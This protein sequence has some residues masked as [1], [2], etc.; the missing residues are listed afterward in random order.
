MKWRNKVIQHY[1]FYILFCAS[2]ALTWYFHKDATRYSDRNE[3]WSDRAGYYIYLP[4]TIFYHFD[5]RKMPVDLDV[6]TGGG[7]SI[8]TLRNK[9][10]TKYTC[11]VALMAAPFFLASGVISR[12]AGYDSESGFSMLYMRMMSLAAVIYLFLGLWFLK[13]F[14]DHYFQAF[15]SFF[16]ITLIFIG[17]NLFYYSLIDGMMSHVYSFFLFALFL[18]AL[19]KHQISGSYR[20]FILLA[21]TLSLA[22]LIR[23]TNILLGFLFFTWDAASPAGCLKRIKQFLKPS[24]ILCFLA[25]LFIVFLPQLIYWKYLSGSWIHFSYRDEGFTNLLHPRILEVLFSPVNGLIPYTPLILFFLAGTGMM[26]THR[27]PNGWPVA[28]VFLMVILV[29]A[30][31]KM[32]YFGCSFG[33]RPFIEYYAVMAVP[34]AYFTISLFNSRSL[35]VKTILFFFVFFFVYFNLRYTVSLYRFER[36]YYGSTWDWDHYFRSVERA[37]VISPVR[38]VQSFENDFE[39]LALCPVFKPSRVFTRSGIYSIS[40]C[41]KGGHTP[42]FSIRLNDF[43]YPYPKMMEVEA[44]VL[45]PGSRLTATSLNYTMNQGTKVLFGDEQPL[46]SV[47]HHPLTWSKV[48][49]T[50]IIPDVNDSSLLISVFIHNPK[51]TPVFIDDLRVKFHYK[52]N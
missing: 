26:I 31:W 5:T 1:F 2:L 28:V 46:D 22:I 18:F 10:D 41:G 16:V 27:K 48:A 49:K 37:G 43:G 9:I 44:W 52:W 7:F 17:T 42:L 14:L 20:Y 32:W 13:R 35:L 12:M 30:S 29:S 15:V 3:L 38:Q 25:I 21:I 8:D 47:L 39:N 11:G 23:P 34:F 4:A 24:Y 45:K 19:K 6:K 50:F 33:Q 51:G 36:C 40:A